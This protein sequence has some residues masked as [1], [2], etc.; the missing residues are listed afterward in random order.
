MNTAR[1]PELSAGHR[2]GHFSIILGVVLFHI[3]CYQLVNSLTL[4]ASLTIRDYSSFIDARI[5]YWSWTGLFYYLG[6]IYILFGAFFISGKL[7][8]RMFH[9]AVAA[10]ILLVMAGAALQLVFAS[11]SPWPARMVTLQQ[12]VHRILWLDRYA[13]LPSMHVALTVFPTCL[14]FSLWPSRLVRSGLVLMTVLIS[15]S[16]LTYKEHVAWDVVAGAVLALAFY[17]VW[18][19]TGIRMKRVPRGAAH[20]A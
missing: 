16:T 3:A 1:A 13:C 10:Y 2:L 17:A 6:D 7:P 4:G 12:T 19:R 5:P 8:H 20:G 9:R 15:L 14:A 11:V 18:S